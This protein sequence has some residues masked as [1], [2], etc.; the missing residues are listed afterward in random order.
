MIWNLEPMSG[1][2]NRSIR[3][4]TAA[5]ISGLILFVLAAGSTTV[6]AFGQT[7]FGTILGSVTD[8]TG[9]SMPG[10]TVTLTNLGTA[11][12]RTISSD[13]NGN[14]QFPS[15]QPGSYS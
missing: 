1:S 8:S 3:R 5:A 15:L 6:R 14:Y 9:A 11:E 4:T 2:M 10:A 7:T 13:A 12:K